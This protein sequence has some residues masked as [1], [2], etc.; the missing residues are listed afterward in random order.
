MDK[1]SLGGLSFNLDKIGL[2][3]GIDLTQALVALSDESKK[4]VVLIIDEAQ[5]AITTDQGVAALFAL[6]AARDELNSAKHHGLRI[7]CTGSIRDKLAMLRNSKDQAFFCASM[8]QFLTLDKDFIE[9]FY[10]NVDLQHPLEPSVVYPL[11]QGSA[12]RPELLGAAAD[13]IRFDFAV[14]EEEIPTRFAE[15][16]R[17]QADDLNANL[18]KVLHSLTPIQSAV[19]RMMS[20][21]GENYAPFEAP[22]LGLY[23][24]AMRQSGIG[25]GEISVEVLGVQQALI[26]LQDKKLVWKASPRL[27]GRRAIDC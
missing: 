25:T 19:I 13:E 22:T 17:A 20:A 4:I 23:G 7:V 21:K 8:M 18:K 15:L 26:A 14:A 16:V 6:K 1:V 12:Y 24:K 5:H 10:A 3:K 9:W 27:C 11:F 2:G